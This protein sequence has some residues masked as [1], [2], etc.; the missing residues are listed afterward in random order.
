[1]K[2]IDQRVSDRIS[3][4]RTLLIFGI[5]LLHVPPVLA[6]ADIGGDPFNFLKY[7]VS[8]GLFR[9][10][11]PVLTCISGYLLFIAHRNFDYRKIVSSKARRILLPFLIW[12]V[13]LVLLLYL[14][15]REH[16]AGHEF[17]ISLAPFDLWAFVNATLSLT[18][19]PVNYPLNF[20]RDLFVLCLISPAFLWLIRK[21][22][23]LGLIGVTIVFN[24]NWDGFLMLRGTMPTCF[25]VGGMFAVYGWSLTRLDRLWPLACLA[26]V[27]ASAVI[28]AFGIENTSW[29]RLISVPLVWIAVAPLV[30]TPF[31]NFLKGQSKDSFFVYVAHAPLLLCLHTLYLSLGKPIVYP[32][33]WILAPIIVCAAA[34]AAIRLL[35][36]VLP[37]FAGFLLGEFSGL[38]VRRPKPIRAQEVVSA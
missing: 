38:R 16:L 4:L 13:P 3:L 24:W 37:A 12:N 28:A 26:L 15:Q 2:P 21:A 5:V 9:A 25:Y 29:F 27:G 32:I 36:R 35:R 7:G 6:A 23:W 1:M 31:G 18:D 11:V 8:R 33:Y 10:T 22:P 17:R 34:I 19:D 30:R 20:L 14:V